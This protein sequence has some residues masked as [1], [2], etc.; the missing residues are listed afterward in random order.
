MEWI[1]IIIVLTP[2]II[3]LIQS[4]RGQNHSDSVHESADFIE[5]FNYFEKK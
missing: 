2:K 3:I 5:K 1:K 4:I